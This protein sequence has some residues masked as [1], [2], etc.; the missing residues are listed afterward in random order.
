[1]SVPEAEKQKKREDK[2]YFCL[3]KPMKTPRKVEEDD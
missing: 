2:K 1:M 3:G